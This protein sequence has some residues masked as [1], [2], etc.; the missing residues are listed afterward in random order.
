MKGCRGEGGLKKRSCQ[1]V[2]PESLSNGGEP[3]LGIP[4]PNAISRTHKA[5]GPRCSWLFV[6]LAVAGFLSASALTVPRPSGGP[7]AVS[8]VEGGPGSGG[9]GDG[10]KMFKMKAVC[11]LN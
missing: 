4:P 10:K 5:R 7:A 11:C 6:S 8:G 2:I 1:K 3:R 9:G